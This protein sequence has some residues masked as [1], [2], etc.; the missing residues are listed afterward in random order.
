MGEVYLVE[1]LL[2]RRYE[3]LKILR[4]SIADSTE[5]A[6][7]FRRE[8]RALHRVTHPNIVALY[9]FGQLEDDRFYLAMEYAKG[10]NMFTMLEQQEK[11]ALNV[12]M[13]ILAKVA[14]AVDHAHSLGVIHR[15]LKPANVVLVRTNGTLEPKILDFGLAKI[16][17][18]EY[19]DS[20]GGTG[21]MALGTPTYMAPEV[22]AN[23]A[24]DHRVDIYSLGCV[25]Y[26]L[27]VGHPPYVGSVMNVLKAHLSE[28]VPR[29]RDN[30]KGR[31]I[32]KE[33]DQLLYGCL[34]KDPNDR[35]QRASWVADV[36]RSC[37]KP[38]GKRRREPTDVAR[39][40]KFRRPAA[41]ELEAA[42]AAEEPEQAE[43]E[44]GE[45][46]IDLARTLLDHGCHDLRLLTAYTS[47]R[48]CENEVHRA[49]FERAAFKQY[50]TSL[51]RYFSEQESC[52]LFALEE[53]RYAA[54]RPTPSAEQLQTLRNS[55][56]AFEHRLN[57]HQ[58]R[59]KREL[60]WARKAEAN[61]L[62]A[63]EQ[64]QSRLVNL[65]HT[66]YNLLRELVPGYDTVTPVPRMWRR[67]EGNV[68]A[69]K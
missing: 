2:L 27:L 65:R 31:K 14:D 43:L 29:I 50:A 20:V 18:P 62:A 4:P 28:N 61:A 1:H 68:R 36:L 40:L 8:A 12:A 44:I 34:Q 32:P 49:Q 58:E 64:A 11:V 21:A 46:L 42:E 69:H 48:E 59:A 52:L 26:E 22:V 7:R 41:G 63:R 39:T 53:L 47:V 10:L 25:A 37:D 57:E 35:V 30:P 38:K 9:D 15:D 51:G 17:A 3:A 13:S 54:T 67:L 5:I 56:L 6:A 24:W 23:R 66:L 55:T 60:K 33:I 19:A 45:T 16:V